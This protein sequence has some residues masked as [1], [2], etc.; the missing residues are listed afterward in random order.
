MKTTTLSIASLVNMLKI[1]KDSKEN[2][3][4]VLDLAEEMTESGKFNS[5]FKENSDQILNDDEGDGLLRLRKDRQVCL[6]KSFFKSFK[7][8]QV[9]RLI[10]IAFNINP[11]AVSRNYLLEFFQIKKNYLKAQDLET[12][13][14]VLDNLLSYQECVKIARLFKMESFILYLSMKGETNGDYDF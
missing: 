14:P 2:I 11:K 4:K 8:S 9:I 7:S 10:R 3:E 13:I 5:E 1:V 12:I 6:S